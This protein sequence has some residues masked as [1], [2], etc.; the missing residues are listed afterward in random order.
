[1]ESQRSGENTSWDGQ[2]LE[3]I[4]ARRFKED[5]A[6]RLAVWRALIDDLFGQYLSPGMRVLDLGCGHGEFINQVRGAERYAM[7][8]NPATGR[9][10]DPA[11]KLFVQD[12]ATPWPLADATLDLIFSSNFFEH[13]PDKEACLRT[14][15]E[16][17]RTL[18]PGW[19][20]HRART[21]YR[22]PSWPLLGF[23]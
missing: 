7:D 16:G 17:L 15:R 14:W 23:F 11:V 10:L 9:L 22:R 20:P 4:Y 21:K 1:M 2:D 8:L 6:Y 19:T 3:S 18:R 13:L 12:C 5:A